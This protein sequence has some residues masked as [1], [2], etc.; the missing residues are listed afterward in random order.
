MTQLNK[1]LIKIL[2]GTS[3]QNIDF[4]DLR[5]LL[6]VLQFSER[7]KG[8]HRIF[9]KDGIEEIINIRLNSGKAKAYQVKQVRSLIL[10]YKLGDKLND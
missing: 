7:I 6:N 1:L 9:F 10:K 2:S 8:S 4:E 5:K 3:D